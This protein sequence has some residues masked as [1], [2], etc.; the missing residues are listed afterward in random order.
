MADSRP[1]N[2]KQRRVGGDGEPEIFMANEQSDVEIDLTRWQ[3][4]ALDVLNAEGIR[5]ATE[6]TIMFVDESTMTE[7]NTQY[8]GNAYATDVL[9]FP[10]DAVEAI[11]SPGPGALSKTPEPAPL[12]LADFPLLLG[13]VVICPSVAVKQAPHHAGTVDDEFALLLV[14]GILHVLGDDHDSPEAEAKMH[15][16][17]RKHLEAFHWRDVAPVNFRHIQEIHTS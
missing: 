14:H 4:L 17:E 12:D 8:M 1:G 7:M 16:R 13:D 11:R 9:S 15:A 5:G 3:Q 6:M 10:L 2:S